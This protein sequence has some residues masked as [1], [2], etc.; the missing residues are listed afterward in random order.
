ME[1]QKF[2]KEIMINEKTKV[3]KAYIIIEGTVEKPYY[4]ILYREIGK[5]YDS[6]GFGSYYLDNVRK[7]KEEY[8]ELVEED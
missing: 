8:L 4:E 2:S 1:S 3:T 5:N 6:I 7:W